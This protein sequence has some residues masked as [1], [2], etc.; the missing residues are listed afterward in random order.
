MLRYRKL[1]DTIITYPEGIKLHYTI[2]S[3]QE[4]KHNLF[5]ILIIEN[6][7][8]QTFPQKRTNELFVRSLPGSDF[9]INWSRD[10]MW[11]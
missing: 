6:H 7:S 5:L 11:D 10:E 3:E 2:E 8:H 1:K 9:P 4:I